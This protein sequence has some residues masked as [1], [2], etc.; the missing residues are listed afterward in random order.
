MFNK[1]LTILITSVVL[2]A[3]ITACKQSGSAEDVGKSIDQKG[4]QAKQAVG[5]GSPTQRAC[6]KID[7]AASKVKNAI[8]PSQ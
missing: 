2:S 5:E 1:V 7:N 8:T 3:S 4:L 6:K